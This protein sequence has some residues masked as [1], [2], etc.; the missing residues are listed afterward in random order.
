GVVVLAGDPDPHR[1]AVAQVPGQRAG[2]DAADPD[3]AL[4]HQFVVQAAGRA[5][6]GRAAGRVADDEPGHPHAPALVVLAVD[7]G[8]ADVRGGHDDDLAV[9]AGVGE[10]LLVAGHAGGE[11][12]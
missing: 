11:D 7:P 2:V 1:A 12:R 10:G 5:P 4:A 3:D 9:V 8:V 6:V